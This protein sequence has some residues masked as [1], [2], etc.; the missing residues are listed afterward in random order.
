MTASH[1]PPPPAHDDT[2]LWRAAIVVTLAAGLVRLLFAALLPLF[3]DETYYWDWSRRLAAG[4][5]DHP[6]AIAHLVAWGTALFGDS[7]IGIRFFPIVAGVVASLSAVAIARRL[8]GARPALLAAVVFALMPLAAS[9]LVLAT[10]D[11]PLLAASAFA[12]LQVVAALQSPVGSRESTVRWLVAGLALGLAFSSKY[13]S[14][15]LPLTVA[16]ALLLRPSLRA[17]FREPGP[18][19][20]CIAATLVFLPVLRWNAQHDWISFRFQIQH[21]LGTPRGSALKRELDL[22]G[23]QLGLVSPV[24]F[25]LFAHA[26]WKTLRT[27]ADDARF[28]L[29]VV[30]TGSWIFFAYSAMRRSVEPNWPAPSYIPGVALLAALASAPRRD[31]WLRGGI[32]LSA[33]LVAVIYLDAVVPVLP[34]PARRDPVA[35][36]FGW[37]DLGARMTIVRYAEGG[38]TFVGADRYQDVSELAYHVGGRPMALCIC[39]TGR[40][41]QYEL[42]PSFAERARRGDNLL[43]ALDDSPGT[44]RSATLLTPHFDAVERGDAVPLMRA[45]DTVTVRRIWMLRGYRGGWPSA[46]P[47]PARPAR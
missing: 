22:I 47:E 36:A 39:L 25:F 3:P 46:P 26:V 2:T 7:R 34:V 13:T 41:N 38:H 12:L 45:G 29:A 5:F 30:A 6:P 32:A 37:D 20:A 18:Y 16:V 43:L 27:R 11:A 21:G 4:Y 33:L 23:G 14:I 9:G 28:V 44:P 15:L 42:W 17:R 35:R 8:G 1:P 19:L 40:H 10:P 31:R 24:I